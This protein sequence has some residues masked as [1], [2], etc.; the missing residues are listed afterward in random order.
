MKVPN[1][2]LPE[3]VNGF[4]TGVGAALAAKLPTIAVE[5]KR[6]VPATNDSMFDLD[7]VEDF[8]VQAKLDKIPTDKASGMP[9]LSSSFLKDALGVL[10][11]EFTHLCNVS[12]GQGVF[13]DAWKM[14]TI[15][16][17]PKIP[18]PKTCSDLRPIS[19]LPLPGRVL[20]RI[21]NSGITSHLER[22]GYLADEQNG[23]RANRSTAKSLAVL[24]DELLEG[25][26]GGEL[27]VTVFLDL[28][29]AFDTVDHEILIWKLEKA[30]LGPNICRL[31]GSYLTS[32]MQAT[33]IDGVLSTARPVTTGVPQGSTLGPLLYIIYANDLARISD[34]PLFT[35][36]ADDT[37]I[38]L[39]GKDLKAIEKQMN[40]IL[41]LVWLW[42]SE[43]K[44]TPNTSKTEYIIFG[45]RARLAKAGNVVLRLGDGVLRGVESYRYLGTT[46][47]ASLSGCRQLSKITQLMA[48][49]LISFQKI[50]AYISEST[51]VMLYKATILPVLDYNDIVY[52]L[53]NKQQL[54]KLQKLQNRALR[55]VYNG[56]VMS[57][58]DM[59]AEAKVD[60]LEDRRD[61]HLLTLMY[62]RATDDTYK[63]RVARVTRRADAV[64]LR[65]PRKQTNVLAKAP[66]CG[67]S[68]MWNDLPAR[69]RRAGTKIGLKN[70]VRQHR[71]GL[72]L[73]RTP[74][75]CM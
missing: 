74:D 23:F 10:L 32:R 39:R 28:K 18:H 47:D 26:D 56:R 20:E 59:H 67:G 24:L 1:H 73:E 33:R 68:V 15:T 70:L 48:Q 63:D 66:V 51:A 61:L 42:F 11:G 35:M 53:L 72:L 55:L 52:Y 54:A 8:E 41:K 7:S 6:F 46:L 69:V 21:L 4:F 49:K 37:T 19:I 2:E 38:T 30:G 3:V 40:Q 50:R 25:M 57:V 27:A 62:S 5:D 29:K 22:T 43:N 58:A 71:A 14:A 64:M 9:N 12:I 34:L 16:P 75:G 65:V 13:P 31:L 45:T 60:Y 36:F 44:L 17:I